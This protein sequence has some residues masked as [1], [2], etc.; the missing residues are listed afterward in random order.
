MIEFVDTELRTV[1]GK[2]NK[3]ALRDRYL[4]ARQPT[5]VVPGERS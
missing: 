1:M 5:A 4:A 3:R 2:V